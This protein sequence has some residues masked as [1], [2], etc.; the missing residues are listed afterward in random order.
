MSQA[1]FGGL[2]Q[3]VIGERLGMARS[4]VSRIFNAL[5]DE[6]LVVAAA[7]RRVRLR[8]VMDLHS[9]LEE[10]CC[11]LQE[12]MDLSM[13]EGDRANSSIK[14]LGRTACGPSVR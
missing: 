1:H 10:L 7:V 12:T 13:L 9:F 4:T 2:N 14:S 5:S 6:G 8:L 3:A 11:E